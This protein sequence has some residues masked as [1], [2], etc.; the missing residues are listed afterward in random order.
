MKK[1]AAT[2][3]E[4]IPHVRVDFYE[5]NGRPYFGELTF[6]HFGAMVPFE[7]EEWDYKFGEWLDLN[8]VKKYDE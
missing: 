6:C 1:I 3:S 8:K 7:P 2:L 5:V 4:G